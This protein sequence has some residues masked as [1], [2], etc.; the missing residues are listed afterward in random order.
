MISS[1]RRRRWLWLCL[2]ALFVL[3]LLLAIETAAL[4]RLMLSTPPAPP[5]GREAEAI[6]V[7]GNRPPVDA[8]GRLRHETRRRLDRGLELLAAG[9]APLLLLAGGSYPGGGTEAEA[10]AEHARS[11]G[12]PN[13]ALLLETSSASTVENARESVRLLCAGRGA[14]CHPA[15]ILVTSPYH[16]ERA[17]DLFRCAGAEVD[18]VPAPLDLPAAERLGLA[19]REALVRFSYL[20]YDPCRRANPAL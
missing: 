19:A 17:T 8:E 1:P 4:Y 3:V 6:V 5:L 7:L 2:G 13:E 12:V 20:F 10:M 18:P 11:A 9:H 14:S 15:L 16:L